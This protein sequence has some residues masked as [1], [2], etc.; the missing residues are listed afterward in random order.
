[1]EKI[2][3]AVVGAAGKMGQEVLRTLLQQDDMDL[4]AAVD[5]NR[6]GEDVGSLIGSEPLHF[7]CLPSIPQ[8]DTIKPDV[9][10]DFTT[11]AVVKGNAREALEMGIHC[12]VGTTGMTHNDLQDLDNLALSK[13]RGIVVA[14]NFAI[15]AILLMR[16]AQEAARYF[17]DAEIIELH[18]NQKLDAPSGT[19][20]KTAEAMIDARDGFGVDN[21]PSN[22]KIKGVRGGEIGGIRIHSVRLPGLVAHQEVLFGGLGQTLTLRHDSLSRESFMPGVMLAVRKVTELK[23]LVYGL[24]HLL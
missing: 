21:T 8:L 22:E 2:K 23:G 15:G 24:E 6:E 12:V 16:F 19:A 11:P 4:V 13:E 18:H 1:M 9:L 7:K 20:I 14:P 17:P 5:P 10:I 3:V